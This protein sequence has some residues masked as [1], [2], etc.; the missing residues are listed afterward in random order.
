MKI[1]FCPFHQLIQS[2][3]PPRG[4]QCQVRLPVQNSEP[5]GHRY[6]DQAQVLVHGKEEA[7]EGTEKGWGQM[8]STCQWPQRP[9]SRRGS[10]PRWHGWACV[11]L[12]GQ[13]GTM[14]YLYH[15]QVAQPLY[16]CW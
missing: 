13:V 7:A 14:P 10:R 4:Y 8:F 2:S 16:C 3:C 9:I 5:A 1:K 11:H 15:S 12:C 6:S